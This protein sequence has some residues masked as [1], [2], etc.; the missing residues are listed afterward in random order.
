MNV[1]RNKL[2]N[3]ET[4]ERLS[5]NFLKDFVLYTNRGH[6][7]KKQVAALSM[8]TGSRLR[9][10]PLGLQVGRAR[11]HIWYCRRAGWYPA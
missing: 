7:L 1:T 3:Y 10:G 2:Y 9:L 11:N 8:P 4:A 6:T 5:V